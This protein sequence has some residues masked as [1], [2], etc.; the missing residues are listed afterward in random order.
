MVQS[1]AD[2]VH[3]DQGSLLFDV[4]SHRPEWNGSLGPIQPTGHQLIITDIFLQ[5]IGHL[6]AKHIYT[7]SFSDSVLVT[8]P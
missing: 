4:S 8:K 3:V 7:T 6:L 2:L 5:L 1:N